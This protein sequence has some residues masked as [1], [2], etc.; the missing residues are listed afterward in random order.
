MAQLFTLSLSDNV[1]TFNF[2]STD[3]IE[4]MDGGFQIG[5]TSK[6]SVVSVLRPGPWFIPTQSDYLPRDCSIRFRVFGADRGAIITKLHKLERIFRNIERRKRL[7]SGKR[8]QLTYAWEGADNLTY[9]EVLDGDPEFPPDIFS[10]EG[11]HGTGGSYGNPYAIFE[12][13]FK[14]SPFG[15]RLSIYSDAQQSSFEIPL[16]N[17]TVGSKQTGGVQVKNLYKPYGGSQNDDYVEIVASDVPGG[18]PYVTVI[19]AKGDTGVGTY[20]DYQTLF[21]G[22]KVAP[23]FTAQRRYEPQDAYSRNGGTLHTGT[24]GYSDGDYWDKTRTTTTDPYWGDAFS[25]MTW[26]IGDPNSEKGL[27]Y[28]FLNGATI[29][30]M[31]VDSHWNIGFYDYVA[32][33]FRVLGEWT[34]PITSRGSLPLGPIVIPPWGINFVDAGTLYSLGLTLFYGQEPNKSSLP[35]DIDSLTLLPI[36]DGLRILQQRGVSSGE[37]EGTAVDDAWRGLTYLMRKSGSLVTNPFFPI[38]N[39]I[40]LEPNVKQRLFFRSLS[41]GSVG[42]TE[43]NR[44]LTVRVYG[45]PTYKTIAD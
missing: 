30:G 28:A 39:P 6:R 8:G 14:I 16:D 44:T 4:V 31:N 1:E 41:F 9:F 40:M 45:V 20:N 42:N 18:N 27:Y 38:L 24:S 22:H 29:A 32:Q 36:D 21:I 23:L 2:L 15:Y 5:T 33:G 7:N 13:R 43:G 10:V 26:L 19:Q 17:S 3:D 25:E 37:L 34:S 12:V 11:L 35:Y